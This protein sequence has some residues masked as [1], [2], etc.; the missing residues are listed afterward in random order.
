M[1][2]SYQLETEEKIPSPDDFLPCSQ[3]FFSNV[4][5]S[6]SQKDTKH[7]KKSKWFEWKRLEMVAT[8][9]SFQQLNLTDR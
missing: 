5:T 2:N 7:V 4:L 9:D 6:K 8:A 3:F 1:Q